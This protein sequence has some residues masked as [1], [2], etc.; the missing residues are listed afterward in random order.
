MNDAQRF[1]QLIKEREV[2]IT[3]IFWQGI[4]IA[5]LFA[6]PLAI[7]VI[8]LKYVFPTES[9]RFIFLGIAFVASWALVIRKYIQLSGTL[10]H[11]DAEIRSL[12]KT[13]GI[14]ERPYHQYPDE[15]EKEAEKQKDDY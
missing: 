8:L 6:L 7:A 2:Y 12:R 5:I 3:R 10:D 9:W 15:I 11:M 1:E 13:L 14:T 4:H